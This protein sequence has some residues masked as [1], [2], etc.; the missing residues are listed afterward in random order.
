[1]LFLEP[2]AREIVAI[3]CNECASSPQ[4]Q[5]YYIVVAIAYALAAF[6]RAI[7]ALVNVNEVV[8]Q[9]IIGIIGLVALASW[10]LMLSSRCCAPCC[11]KEQMPDVPQPCPPGPCACDNANILDYPFHIAMIGDLVSEIVLGFISTRTRELGM[12]PPEEYWMLRRVAILWAI[13]LCVFA[14]TGFRKFQMLNARRKAP[15]Q[16]PGAVVGAPVTI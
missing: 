6:A 4:V 13:L 14:C 10:I 12:L 1:M 5:L 8:V 3:C 16:M 2:C 9:W 7:L 15:V 11:C